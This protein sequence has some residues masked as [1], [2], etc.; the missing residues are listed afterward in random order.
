MNWS[1]DYWDFSRMEAQTAR[2]HRMLNVLYATVEVTW[3]GYG[4]K[5]NVPCTIKVQSGHATACDA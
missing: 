3:T 1:R 4:A 2:F 5:P